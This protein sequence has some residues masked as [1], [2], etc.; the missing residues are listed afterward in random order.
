LAL[1]PLVLVLVHCPGY[2]SRRV[3]LR[4][5]SPPCGVAIVPTL[6]SLRFQLFPPGRSSEIDDGGRR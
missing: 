4:G 2:G 5:P 6:G 1:A 3:L